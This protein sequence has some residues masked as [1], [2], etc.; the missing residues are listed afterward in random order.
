MAKAAHI[1]YC[2]AINIHLVQ[3]LCPEVLRSVVN[4]GKLTVF[5][6]RT[7]FF[8]V[9]LPF[10]G[11]SSSYQLSFTCVQTGIG[12]HNRLINTFPFGSGLSLSKP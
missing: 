12:Q 4:D 8:I 10:W 2:T 9:Y 1:I 11:N 6:Y 3:N 7:D 5:L